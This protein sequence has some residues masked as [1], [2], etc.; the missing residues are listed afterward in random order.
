MGLSFSVIT[1][2]FQQG[3]FI[4]RTI[5]SVIDQPVRDLEY[6]VCDG[7]SRDE[8]LP[9]LKTY[10]RHL[11]WISEPDKGQAH[12]VNKGLEMTRGEII[13]WINSD[14]IYY[15]QAF[16]QVLDVFEN[17]PNILVVYGQAN[18]I[19]KLNGVIAPY[20]TQPWNYK[21]LKKECYLCQP[22]VFFRRRLVE[23]SG[24]L[25]TKLHYCMDYELWLRYGRVVPFFYLP[26]KLA[27][28]RLYADNKTFSGR[29]AAHHE[30]NQMLKDQLGYSTRH[31][32]FE[33]SKL[34]TEAS[35]SPDNL[36]F[37]FIVSFVVAGFKNCWHLNKKSI[38]V[39]LIKILLYQLSGYNE[40]STNK[41]NFD[42]EKA[43]LNRYDQT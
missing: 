6:I 5:Q 17:N 22:A 27:G 25:N 23:Y 41:Q 8:T 29:L 12:A 30:A 20:P 11:R 9:I 38:L 32:I 31:W 40:P 13:A 16:Q 21:Q 1:P 39:V 19:D 37:I 15:P 34:Q 42:I 10:S 24:N 7:G 28:S 4:E 26:V 35:H 2:S 18:W 14:D 43:M 33:Y 3:K 36:K